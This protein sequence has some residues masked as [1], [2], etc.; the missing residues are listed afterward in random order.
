MNY[1]QLTSLSVVFIF[2]LLYIHK[3]SFFSIILIISYAKSVWKA[4][5]HFEHLQNQIHS[6]VANW[7]GPYCISMNTLSQEL[8]SNETLNDLVYCVTITFFMIIYLP[9]LHVL[10]K[11]LLAKCYIS[12]AYLSTYNSNFFPKLKI[13]IEK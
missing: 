5:N 7:K 3:V 12:Q 11:I 9:I 10:G 13:I 8:V 6:F 1:Y 2:N 4:D